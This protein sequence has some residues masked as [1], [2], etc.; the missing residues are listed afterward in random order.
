MIRGT[1]FSSLFFPLAR[2]LFAYFKVELTQ[3]T[4]NNP[5]HKLF[6]FLAPAEAF[7]TNSARDF[8]FR[9]FASRPEIP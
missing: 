9:F 1:G 6:P 3:G 5:N 8:T 2:C 7:P 4:F